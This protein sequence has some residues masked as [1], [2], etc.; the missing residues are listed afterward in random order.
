M[1]EESFLLSVKIS[2]FLRFFYNSLKFKISFFLVSFIIKSK[3]SFISQNK[4]KTI[5]KY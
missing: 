3:K 2:Q 5:L 4:I 1:S